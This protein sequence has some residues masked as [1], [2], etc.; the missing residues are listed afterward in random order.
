[1]GAGAIITPGPV[2]TWNCFS[3]WG[4]DGLP[5]VRPGVPVEEGRVASEKLANYP[6]KSDATTRC[7][8]VLL[9]YMF[10]KPLVDDGVP[11][12]GSCTL[13]LP[14]RTT[15]Y[16]NMVVLG[17]REHDQGL[18]EPGPHPAFEI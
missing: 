4:A 14:W 7:P 1:M 2:L 18:E 3:V 8:G 13:R 17:L 10:S 6:S 5:F 15:V 16:R 9:P 11:S 12:C